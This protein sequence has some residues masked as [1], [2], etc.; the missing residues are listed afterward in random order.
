[1]QVSCFM[2]KVSG[3]RFQVEECRFQVAG[4]RFQVAGCRLPVAGCRL[5]VACFRLQVAGCK[6]QVAGCRLQV[7]GSRFQEPFWLKPFLSNGTLFAR[8]VE[9]SGSVVIRLWFAC[10]TRPEARFFAPFSLVF[11]RFQVMSQPRRS[12][13]L[14]ARFQSARSSPPSLPSQPMPIDLTDTEPISDGLSD[15]PV[16]SEVD[17]F[18]LPSC[19]VCDGHFAVSGPFSHCVL[20]CC[21][22]PVHLQCFTDLVHESS[23][24]VIWPACNSSVPFLFGLPPLPALVLRSPGGGC[25]RRVHDLFLSSVLCIFF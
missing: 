16:L 1:M 11:T 10:K 7:A 15:D 3:L 6:L 22:L 18:P 12:A 14:A 20:Q 21:D 25:C 9:G 2:L 4:C 17:V 24:S 23:Q 19:C 5:Q 8:V 13:R